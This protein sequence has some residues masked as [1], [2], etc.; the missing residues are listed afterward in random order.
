MNRTS[1]PSKAFTRIS[2]GFALDIDRRWRDTED[3]PYADWIT[4][5]ATQLHD[6]QAAEYTGWEEQ[7]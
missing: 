1:G 3:D 2:R 7:P 5:R 4:R 6:D